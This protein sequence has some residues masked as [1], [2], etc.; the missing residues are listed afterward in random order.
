[1]GQLVKAFGRGIGAT[2]AHEVGH[3]DNAFVFVYPFTAHTSTC[4]DCYDYTHLSRNSPYPRQQFFG[5]LHW[6]E[7]A[8]VGM[9]KALPRP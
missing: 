4:L 8:Q 6:S 3:Q 1:M 2:S 7:P 5:P 9:R